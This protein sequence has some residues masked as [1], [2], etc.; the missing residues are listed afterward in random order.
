MLTLPSRTF[1]KEATKQQ[2]QDWTRIDYPPNP[3][4][5][6]QKWNILDV[7]FRQD[8]GQSFGIIEEKRHQRQ[9]QLQQQ[10]RQQQQQ[11]SFKSSY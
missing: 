8:P 5:R 10:Q 2:E 4:S 11:R 7:R 3:E 6:L 9:Q 1:M